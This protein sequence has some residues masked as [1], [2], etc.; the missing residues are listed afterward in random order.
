MKSS[1]TSNTDQYIHVCGLTFSVPRRQHE[2]YTILAGHWSALGLCIE[3]GFVGLDTGCL[4]GGKLTAYR[5]EDGEVF[6]VNA[7][8]ATK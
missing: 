3:P 2:G 6:Q 5:L 7:A 1:G 8:E 4:W